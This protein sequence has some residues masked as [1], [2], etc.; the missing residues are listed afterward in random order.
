MNWQEI[1]RTSLH[2]FKVCWTGNSVNYLY[3]MYRYV[4]S[5]NILHFEEYCWRISYISL[6]KN[7][8]ILKNFNHVESNVNHYRNIQW[9]N[10]WVN[11][12]CIVTSKHHNI[13]TI[14][15]SF[16]ISS[17]EKIEACRN[18]KLNCS[19]ITSR[20]LIVTEKSHMY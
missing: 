8:H 7:L 2:L 17:G 4:I 16:F 14:R 11:L 12:L 6:L 5:T 3:L 9:K 10:K 15:T 18:L 19:C 13:L 1:W 20:C